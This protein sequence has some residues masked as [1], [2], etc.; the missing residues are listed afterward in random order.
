MEVSSNPHHSDDETA[1]LQAGRGR[2]SSR[3]LHVFFGHPI[4][5]LLPALAILLVGI[6]SGIQQTSEYRS[7]GTLNVSTVTF[8]GTL[9]D[10]RT[11]PY[12]ADTAAAVTARQFNELMRTDGFASLVA[13]NAGLESEVKCMPPLPATR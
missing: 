8:L 10:T 4:L 13:A 12:K 6:Y 3:A 1:P 9:S 5:Y 7:V 2:F 11:D